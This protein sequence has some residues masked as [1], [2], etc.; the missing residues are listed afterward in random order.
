MNNSDFLATTYNLKSLFFKLAIS[1]WHFP[2]EK[3]SFIVK[4]I[5]KNSL[6]LTVVSI[7]WIYELKSGIL[8]KKL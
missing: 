8:F 5:Y 3:L 1:T 4:T 6:K 7:L 2:F